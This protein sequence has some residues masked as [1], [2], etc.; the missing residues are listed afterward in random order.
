MQNSQAILN[1]IAFTL[2][3]AEIARLTTI[4]DFLYLYATD[5]KGKETFIQQK[6]YDSVLFYS[7]KI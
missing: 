6:N 7:T 2:M 1:G 5:E 3:L 4:N